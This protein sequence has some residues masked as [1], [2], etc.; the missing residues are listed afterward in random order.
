[1]WISPKFEETKSVYPHK[2]STSGRTGG[3]RLYSAIL[4]PGLTKYLMPHLLLIG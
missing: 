1:M 4:G 3:G 2:F